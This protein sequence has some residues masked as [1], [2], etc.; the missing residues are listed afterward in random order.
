[1]AEAN[2][3]PFGEWLL[4]FLRIQKATINDLTE[5]RI[6]LEPGVT[7]LASDRITLKDLKKLQTN[8]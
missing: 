5:A 1:M 4:S 7:G 6:I 8:T 2:P 3:K